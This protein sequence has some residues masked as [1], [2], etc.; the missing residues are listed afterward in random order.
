MTDSHIIGVVQ[1]MRPRIKLDNQQALQIGRA[2]LQSVAHIE[3]HNERG[4]QA[5]LQILRAKQ[6]LPG[7]GLADG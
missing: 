3:D 7:H 2:A 5:A 4:Y 6:N 1:G